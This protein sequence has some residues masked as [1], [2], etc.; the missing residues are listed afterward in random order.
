[1]PTLKREYGRIWFNLWC[2]ALQN[3]DNYVKFFMI[4]LLKKLKILDGTETV[5]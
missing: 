3:F 1:M 5:P 4:F 2:I